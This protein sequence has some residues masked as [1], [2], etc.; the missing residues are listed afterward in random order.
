VADAEAL[1]RRFDTQGPAYYSTRMRPFPAFF[2]IALLTVFVCGIVRAED[3]APETSV[4]KVDDGT[5]TRLELL[6]AEAAKRMEEMNPREAVKIYTDILLIEPDD[7]AAYTNMGQAYLMLGDSGRAKDAFLNALHI[8]PDNDIALAGLKNIADP[9]S[10][11]AL[12][13]MRDT[14]EDPIAQDNQNKL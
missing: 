9:D 4:L 1:W 6:H 7:D 8:D 12:S 13:E 5:I 14:L 2:G 11:I 10:T 3:A